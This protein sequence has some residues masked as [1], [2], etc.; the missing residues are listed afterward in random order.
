MEPTQPPLEWVPGGLSIGVK[1][2]EREADHLV[3]RPRMHGAIPPLPNTFSWRG[4][5]LKKHRDCTSPV[6]LFDF[7]NLD[8]GITA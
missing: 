2:P 7:S 1:L 3:S 6:I 4:V 8:K 5:Q